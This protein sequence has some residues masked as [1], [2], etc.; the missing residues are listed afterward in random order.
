MVQWDWV[1]VHESEATMSDTILS[2]ESENDDRVHDDRVH[3]DRMY[4]DRM[5]DDAAE[6]GGVDQAAL[7]GMSEYSA[8]G[9]GFSEPHVTCLDEA[10]DAV[11]E[12]SVP[13]ARSMR[14][15]YRYSLGRMTQDAHLD[16]DGAW[17]E[18]GPMHLVA[19]RAR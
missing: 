7:A 13:D 5:Y 1:L 14:E 2:Y 4:D 12:P 8:T 17:T 19:R 9:G 6:D 11:D 15:L 18:G 16:D 10:H 3:D